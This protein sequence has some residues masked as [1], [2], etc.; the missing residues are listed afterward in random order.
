MS[1]PHLLQLTSLPLMLI[2]ASV[3]ARTLP[4][5]MERVVVLPVRAD[6]LD[7]AETLKVEGLLVGAVA[8][9]EVAAVLG[10]AELAERLE[11]GGATFTPGCAD[12]RCAAA[13]GRGLG[14]TSV[15]FADIRGERRG[16]RLVLTLVDAVSGKQVSRREQRLAASR[17]L[18]D[19]DVDVAVRRAF[20]APV[21]P[22]ARPALGFSTRRPEH[23]ERDYERLKSLI[24]DQRRDFDAKLASVES[25]IDAYATV[26]GREID[27]ALVA[28]R[29]M[30]E[31]RAYFR[32]QS[33][34]AC[35]E[36]SDCRSRGW[37]HGGDFACVAHA[38]SDC[39]QANVCVQRGQ[40]RADA[41]ACSAAADVDCRASYD[42]AARG[43]CV[44]VGGACVAG[45]DSDCRSASVCE[46][47]GACVA[48]GG[49]CVDGSNAP[50]A[51]R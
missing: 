43:L 5:N 4:R 48:A 49:V 46:S 16:E 47:E 11:Q 30:L 12:A 22:R 45:S 34:E 20:G 41:G 10:P 21:L 25:F 39:R 23:L 44:A 19:R 31:G 15:I 40:C 28:R 14:A 38:D 32:P 50:V 2:A 7:G 26:V 51:V 29:L 42:C 18:W 37:C 17:H 1:R 35:A 27:E 36:S 8:H 33:E 24:Y 6:K 13:L 9:L 3:A